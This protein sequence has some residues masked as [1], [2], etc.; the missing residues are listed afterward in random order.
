MDS[1]NYY[2]VEHTPKKIPGY[3]PTSNWISRFLQLV[4]TISSM[5]KFN[6]QLNVNTIDWFFRFDKPSTIHSLVRSQVR[7]KEKQSLHCSHCINDDHISMLKEINLKQMSNS[8]FQFDRFP[9]EI[10]LTILKNLDNDQVLYSLMGVNQRLN[11]FLHDSLFTNHLTLMNRSV[12]NHVS[13]LSE[14]VLHRFC[15][16]ILP[17]IHHQIQWLNIESSSMKRIL[18]FIYPNL[19]GLGLYNLDNLEIEMMTHFTRMLFSFSEKRKSLIF[20]LFWYLDENLFTDLMKNQIKSLVICIREYRNENYLTEKNRNLFTNLLMMFTNLE[21]FKF[22]LSL[23]DDQ[24][25]SFEASLLWISSSKLLE[26]HVNVA[27]LNDCLYLLDGRFDQLRIFYVQIFRIEYNSHLRS[28]RSV[29]LFLHEEL[30]KW[31][32]WFIEEIA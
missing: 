7:L 3:A 27:T 26:L 2:C 12:T 29:S 15:S 10:L 16:Q 32:F 14:R 20:S 11:R 5:K 30:K 22:G 31:I 28:H 6:W 21:S 23:I 4:A 24:Y 9:D 13:P 18:S 19:N 1:L 8:L 25:I 17:E